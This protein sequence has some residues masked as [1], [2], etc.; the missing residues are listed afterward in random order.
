M[1]LY[2]WDLFRDVEKFKMVAATQTAR[3]TEK[4]K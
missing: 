3:N 1:E 4:V 2:F